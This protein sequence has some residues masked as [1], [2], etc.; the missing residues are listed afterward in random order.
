MQYSRYKTA[1]KNQIYQLKKKE[2]N[3]I[4]G[5]LSNDGDSIA[6]NEDA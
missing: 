2:K 3:S 5:S 4:K 1:V 6:S